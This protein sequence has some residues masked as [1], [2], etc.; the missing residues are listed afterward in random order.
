MCPQK[1]PEVGYVLNPTAV[2]PAIF[3]LSANAAN[4]IRSEEPHGQ[5]ID[6][7]PELSYSLGD[8]VRL[9]QAIH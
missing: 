7:K 1:M 3:T 2:G 8:T 5:R 6:I 4:F 9:T